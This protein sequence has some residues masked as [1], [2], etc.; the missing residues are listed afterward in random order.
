MARYNIEIG[1]VDFRSLRERQ[2]CYV[3]KTKF[4]EELLA[5][6]RP[7]VS[8]ITRPRRF[9]KTLTMNMLKEFFDIRRKGTTSF[10]GLAIK[11]NHKLCEAWMNKFPVL[12]LSLKDVGTGDFQKALEDMRGILSELYDE[13]AYLA[14]TARS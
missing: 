8:L 12:S 4:M 2:L 13:H 9:G 14:R 11:R 1:C 7:T 5:A 3:D 6:N 10:D